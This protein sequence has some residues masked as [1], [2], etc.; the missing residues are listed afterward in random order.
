[1]SAWYKR[2]LGRCPGTPGRKGG[3]G[4]GLRGRRRRRARMV[5]RET[6]RGCLGGFYEWCESEGAR[7]GPF[8]GRRGRARGWPVGG[9][10]RGLRRSSSGRDGPASMGGVCGCL[11]D[12]GGALALQ[13]DDGRDGEQWHLRTRS[14]TFFSSRS[15]GLGSQRAGH[16]RE[17]REATLARIHSHARGL[18]G[19]GAG[20]TGDQQWQQVAL[21]PTNCST[22]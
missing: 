1:L 12:V 13:D 7:R 9:H 8:I 18:A 14:A 11:G 4:G 15:S 5:K 17:M 16:G 2:Q 10:G 21:L 3:R 6:R 20:C 19:E 22:K